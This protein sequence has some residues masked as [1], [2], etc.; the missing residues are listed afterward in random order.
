MLATAVVDL[1][2]LIDLW[3][4]QAI[5]LLPSIV[6]A[7]TLDIVLDECD[8]AKN[9]G[10]RC[11]C[12]AASIRKVTA[13]PSWLAQGLQLRTAQ[14]SVVDAVLLYYAQIKQRM[15]L[16]SER[17]L[18]KEARSRN[19]HV[20]GTLWV[21]QQFQRGNFVNTKELCRWLDVLEQ[22]GRYLPRDPITAMK[23]QWNCQ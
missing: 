17:P 22:S 10:L 16:T 9:P 19:I 20:H 4:I 8:K 13:E 15:L 6:Q 23:K 12:A 5:T 3:Y 2:V 14:L 11:Q 18:R 1:N 21:L 7:E